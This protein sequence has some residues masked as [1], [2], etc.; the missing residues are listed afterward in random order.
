MEG[1]MKQRWS[2]S[3][4]EIVRRLYPNAPRGQILNALPGRRWDYIIKRAAYI[5]VRRRI[6]LP[7][8]HPWTPAEDKVMADLFGT[9]PMSDMVRLLPN[10]T[11]SSIQKRATQLGLWRSKDEKTQAISTKAHHREML[12]KYFPPSRPLKV[13]KGL[14]APS[15]LRDLRDG[16]VAKVK[17]INASR[18][19]AKDLRR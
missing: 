13:R 15:L 3:E 6:Y 1:T 7:G 4:D 5:G 12:Q 2:E 19:A 10:H 17:Q 8:Q 9:T 11:Y 14:D 16:I 18:L